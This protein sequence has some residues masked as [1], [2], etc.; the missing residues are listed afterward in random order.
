MRDVGLLAVRRDSRGPVGRP[1][2]RYSLAPDAPS[3][4]LEP[5]A[6]PVLARMLAEV[7]AA[8]GVAAETSAAA[9]AAQGRALAEAG[10]GARPGRPASRP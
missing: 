6:F 7:A 8:A 4:G 10:P 9:G 3:L 5:P 1:Q 2:H